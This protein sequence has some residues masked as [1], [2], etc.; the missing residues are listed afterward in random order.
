MLTRNLNPKRGLCNGTR[1]IC[2][3]FT[4]HLIEAEIAIGNHKGNVQTAISFCIS[5]KKGHIHPLH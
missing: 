5:L 4:A 1:L 3:R 2:K